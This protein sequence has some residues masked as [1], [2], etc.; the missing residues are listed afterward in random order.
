MDFAFSSSTASK[1]CGPSFRS[2][3]MDPILEA[4]I[5]SSLEERV[6]ERRKGLENNN[7]ITLAVF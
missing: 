5:V 3:G 7:L 1:V 4:Q 6:N 2:I